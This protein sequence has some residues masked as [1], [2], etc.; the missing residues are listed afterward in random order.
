MAWDCLHTGHGKP[1]AEMTEKDK[2][3]WDEQRS[4]IGALRM[5][6]ER[7]V[8]PD[9]IKEII[10][11]ISLAIWY[12]DEEAQLTPDGIVRAIRREM[13]L[14]TC[15]RRGRTSTLPY[16]ARDLR[17]ARDPVMRMESLKQSL[18]RTTFWRFRRMLRKHYPDLVARIEMH[19]GK[20]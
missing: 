14:K 17:D 3:D 19:G 9:Q 8:T 1:W 6:T 15:H 5:W 11:T 12:V 18:P 4:I 10:H 16:L 2:Q 7:G 20:V 13:N